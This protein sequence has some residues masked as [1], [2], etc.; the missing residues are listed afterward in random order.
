M[1]LSR[2]SATVVLVVLS[3]LLIAASLCD[4]TIGL[5]VANAQYPYPPA[6]ACCSQIGKCPLGW[7]QPPG[8]A[9]FCASPYGP[10]G[11]F[12]CY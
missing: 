7:P 10:I 6:T 1:R 5:S 11:G 3:L 9:C 2:F 12:A 4:M 8:S